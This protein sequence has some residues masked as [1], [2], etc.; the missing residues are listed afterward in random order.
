MKNYNWLQQQRHY[1][2]FFS[3]LA[4]LLS[5]L[6]P[7]QNGNLFNL[8]TVKLCVVQKI[9]VEYSIFIYSKNDVWKRS[10][11]PKGMI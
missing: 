5:L 8:A 4:A 7:V 11:E 2:T 3:R 9:P 10:L 1:K 6:I